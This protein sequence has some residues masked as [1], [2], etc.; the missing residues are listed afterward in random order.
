[1]KIGIDIGG[2]KIR[3]GIVEDGRIIKKV[4]KPTLAY[5]EEKEI[6]DDLISGIKEIICPEVKSIGVGVPSV[7]DTHLGIVYNVANI[8]SWKE[9]HLKDILE[10]EFQL[11]VFIN[12]DANCFVQGEY[13][14]GKGA[15]YNNVVGITIG[16]GLGAGL[17]LDGKLY[18][19]ANTSAGEVGNFPYL[20]N[21]FEYYCSG[22]YFLH[23][24]QTTGYDLAIEAEAENQD[25]LDKF[26]KFGYHLGKLIMTVLFAYD[27]EAIIIGG[28]IA[29]SYKFYSSEM[30]KRVMNE[31]PYSTVIENLSIHIS[32]RDDIGILGATEL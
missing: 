16:T 4:E 3:T 17:I 21:E 5:R 7:V 23:E 11:P 30:N 24:Y 27:P 18:N 32:T 22:Q 2:T 12:N 6:I 13:K 19:G 10:Q 14:Y 8:K 15:G 9:V 31:F 20:D 29:Q 26:N 1:M 25:A 28:S